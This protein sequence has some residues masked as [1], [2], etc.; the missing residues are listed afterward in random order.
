M[1]SEERE[2]EHAVERLVQVA[3]IFFT[4]CTRA[5]LQLAVGEMVNR[6]TSAPAEC[7][8]DSTGEA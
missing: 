5:E 7:A 6:L 2:R 3:A 4:R 1:T 8:L